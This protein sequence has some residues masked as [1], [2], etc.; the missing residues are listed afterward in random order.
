M[1]ADT[2]RVRG[3]RE[4]SSAL[5]RVNRGARVALAAGLKAAAEPIAADA[6]S[7]LSGYGGM[8]TNTIRPR[9]TTQGVYVTQAAKKVTGRRPDFGSLQM[10]KGLIPAAYGRQDDIVTKVEEAFLVLTKTEGF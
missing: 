2:I 7:R 6:R 9:A 4:T 8:K 5:Y 3:Y 10:V 1:A